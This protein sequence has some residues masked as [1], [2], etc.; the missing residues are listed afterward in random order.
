MCCWHTFLFFIV[1][2]CT[3]KCNWIGDDTRLMANKQ[4]AEGVLCNS[5]STSAVS[6]IFLAFVQSFIV[7]HINGNRIS[8]DNFI[9]SHRLMLLCSDF[10]CE[11]ASMQFRSHFSLFSI[12]LAILLVCFCFRYMCIYL[13]I[14]FY[15]RIWIHNQMKHRFFF[16]QM[17]LLEYTRLCTQVSKRAHHIAC[18]S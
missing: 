17:I 11:I 7:I 1:I 6:D 14:I 3:F 12:S 16:L 10:K 15:H 4:R 5:A 18:D 9:D 2:K 8:H 13:V